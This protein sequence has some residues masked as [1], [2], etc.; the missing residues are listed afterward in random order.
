MYLLEHCFTAV[1]VLTA[2]KSTCYLSSLGFKKWV[3]FQLRVCL[4]VQLKLENDHHLNQEEKT[5]SC[6][7]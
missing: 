3:W 2:Q 6:G 1:I 7:L 4:T 5:P